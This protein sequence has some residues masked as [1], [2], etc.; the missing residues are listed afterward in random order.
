VLFRSD[1]DEDEKNR[2]TFH[3]TLRSEEI[4]AHARDNARN[5]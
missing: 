4:I 2:C 3:S 5:L 1:G